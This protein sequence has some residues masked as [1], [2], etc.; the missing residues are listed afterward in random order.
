M[1]RLSS[2]V[3]GAILGIQTQDRTKDFLDIDFSYEH[4]LY[5]TSTMKY[6]RQ[7]HEHFIQSGI[8][9][10]TEDFFLQGEEGE[11]SQKKIARSTN[12]IKGNKSCTISMLIFLHNLTIQLICISDEI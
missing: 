8:H 3:Q 12:K 4:Y 5:Q 9:G 10:R 1:D 6:P 11:I 7:R 2:F